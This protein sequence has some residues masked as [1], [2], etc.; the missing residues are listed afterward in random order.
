MHNVKKKNEDE[1]KK[2]G[3]CYAV[4]KRHG[5]LGGQQLV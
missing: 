3:G 5:D 4:G 2:G 1:A